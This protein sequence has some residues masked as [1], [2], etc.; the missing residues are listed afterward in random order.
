METSTRQFRTFRPG[1]RQIPASFLNAIGGFLQTAGT[2]NIEGGVAPSV[3]RVF[4]RTGQVLDY[5]SCV[6]IESPLFAIP[7]T[8]NTGPQPD[9]INDVADQARHFFDR[10]YSAVLPTEGHSLGIIMGPCD[11]EQVCQVALTGLV[12]AVVDVIN[13]DHVAVKAKAGTTELESADEGEGP[14][15]FLIK[16]TTTGKQWCD[17]VFGIASGG[18]GFSDLEITTVTSTIPYNGSGTVEGARVVYGHLLNQFQSIPNGTRVLIGTAK[19]N[20]TSLLEVIVSMNLTY[21]AV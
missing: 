8:P 4:N 15:S 21:R 17:L 16:P 19:Y 12:R 14:I 5:G 2:G 9:D 6:G 1:D 20:N 13:T 10:S 3:I 7:S 18:G 11:V